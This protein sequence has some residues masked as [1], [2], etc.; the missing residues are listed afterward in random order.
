[1]PSVQGLLETALYVNDL[2]K[3]ANFYRKLFGFET[4]LASERL[5]AL[6]VVGR[7]VLLLFKEGATNEPF[8]TP[9][10][11]IP[12]HSGSGQNHLAFSVA[13][14]DVPAWR[15]RLHAQGITIESTVTWERGA[16]SLYFRDPDRHLVELI[17]PGFW[18]TY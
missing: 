13:A 4:L 9:C 18:R 5:V 2:P 11:I 6:D 16:Q 7:N 17:T 1:M 8:K 3:A 14:E 10:G 15:E 12:G